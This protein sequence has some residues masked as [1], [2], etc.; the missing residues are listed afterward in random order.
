MKITLDQGKVLAK[1]AHGRQVDQQARTYLDHHLAGVAARLVEHGEEA[2]MAGWL[3]DVLEDTV[4]TTDDLRTAG[5]PDVVVEAVVA[6]SKVEGQTYD[7]LIDRAAAHPLGRLVK[8]ADN[9]QNLADNPVL[10]EVDPEKAAQLR[11]KYERARATL[12][13]VG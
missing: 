3:H 12:V 1:A 9:A 7:E 10:A 2:V 13:T 8:L 6:V 4:L 5:V 11:A